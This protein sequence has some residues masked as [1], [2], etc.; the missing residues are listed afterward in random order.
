MAIGE[1]LLCES[2]QFARMV[3]SHDLKEGLAAWKERREPRYAGR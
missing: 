2:E 1:G 3:P